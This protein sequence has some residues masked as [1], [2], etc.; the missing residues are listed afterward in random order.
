MCIRDRKVIDFF[1]DDIS[2]NEGYFVGYIDVKIIPEECNGI[3]GSEGQCENGIWLSDGGEWEC[4]SVSA[5]LLG[6]NS[7]LS[8]QWFD[9]G[10]TLSGSDSD[11]EPIYLRIV[12]YPE[13]YLH[14]NANQTAVNEFQALSPWIVEGWGDGVVSVQV[15]LDVNSYG[16]WG[17][18]DD[19]EEITIQV[20]VHQFR[21]SA[22]LISE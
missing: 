4:D 15:N 12:T 8:G 5:T 6:D 16:G 20:S 18:M 3:D 14:E 1:L 13:Y 11:C 2:A 9:S 10:N 19:S 22:N 7:S 17:P 21:P